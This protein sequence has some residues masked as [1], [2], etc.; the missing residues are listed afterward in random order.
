MS[1]LALVSLI[2]GSLASPTYCLTL[3]SPGISTR[4]PISS[5]RYSRQA[6]APSACAA[7]ERSTSDGNTAAPARVDM[8]TRREMLVLSTT[9]SNERPPPSHG[10]ASDG[11]RSAPALQQRQRIQKPA[12]VRIAVDTALSKHADADGS[13]SHVD[14]A[15]DV[16]EVIRLA[17]E[18]ACRIAAYGARLLACN[19]H[20]TR[21]HALAL[22]LVLVL[23]RGCGTIFGA[24]D[25]EQHVMEFNLGIDRLYERIAWITILLFDLGRARHLDPEAH[26]VVAIFPPGRR[27]RPHRGRQRTSRGRGSG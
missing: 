22:L 13:F 10:C 24:V 23:G 1:I 20:A 9:K 6:A 27:L 12:Y 14:H 17:N 2:H 7:V 5:S 16:V 3:K 15:I 25:A 4:K 26:L 11:C 21:H 18:I 19:R 8:T